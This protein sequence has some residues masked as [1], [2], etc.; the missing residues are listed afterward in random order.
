MATQEIPDSNDKVI[1]RVMRKSEDFYG[2]KKDLSM[3]VLWDGVI[4]VSQKDEVNDME[5]KFKS[6]LS[7]YNRTFEYAKEGYDNVPVASFCGG[8]A[9]II[10]LAYDCPMHYQG[11]MVISKPKY[12]C[13][14]DA[15]GFVHRDNPYDY[16]VYPTIFKYIDEFQR[17]YGDALIS[18][19]DTQSPIDVFNLLLS[20]EQAMYAIY[21]DPD[22]SHKLLDSIT[23]SIIAINHHF[24]ES[25]HNFSGYSAEKYLP[26]GLH[27]SDDDAAYL[28]PEV[29]RE[30]A[31]PYANRLSEEFGGVNFHVCLGYE[32]NLENIT[33]TKGFIGCDAMPDYNDND[34]IMKALSKHKRPVWH[35]YN[36]GWT[37]DS[38][39]PLSDLEYFKKYLDMAQEH[40]IAVDIGIYQPTKYDCLK[41]ADQVLNYALSKGWNF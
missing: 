29:Y 32:Q 3:T 8:I 23:K 6:M 27:L 40:G 15:E 1:Q 22:L 10:A 41:F 17:R 39:S 5:K 35:V 38:E 20:V 30:F 28:S 16:G 11:D 2:G 7:I 24:K 4:G 36:Y 21:D 14:E 26:R 19:S 37:R 25:I 31:L 18:V 9:Y 33:D 12:S 13:I 34:K